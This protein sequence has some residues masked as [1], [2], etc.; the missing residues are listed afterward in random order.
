MLKMYNS[1]RLIRIFFLPNICYKE[2]VVRFIE[3]IKY[4]FMYTI[5]EL[6]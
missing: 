5:V 6:L 3:Q 1:I 4:F 2:F